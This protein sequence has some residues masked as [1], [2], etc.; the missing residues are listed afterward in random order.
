MTNTHKGMSV[1]TNAHTTALGAAVATALLC[2][3][4]AVAG[5]QP[6]QKGA[7][8]TEQYQSSSKGQMQGERKELKQELGS[9]TASA[10]VVGEVVEVRDVTIDAP[11]RDQHR[12]VKV[13]SQ[14][15][16]TMVIDIGDADAADDFKLETG[17]RI[18]AVGKRARINDQPVLFVK[19]I[20]EL[21]SVGQHNSQALSG[22]QGASMQ[23]QARSGQQPGQGTSEGR[24]ATMSQTGTEPATVVY[25]FESDNWA[26]DQY[27]TYDADFDWETSEAWYSDWS[28]AESAWT[29]DYEV[30][31]YDMF[32][33]DDA[34]DWGMWDW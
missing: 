1:K 3:G 32:G 8:Q 18:L 10:L 22:Q 12:L 26:N 14:N 16:S 19:T 13:K 27:G 11:V 9:T 34:G 20:G 5:D 2:A 15:G 17:D 24:S 7:Q 28:D 4:S 25:L 31:H 30:A 21:H 29:N 23:S 33:Y 6:Y